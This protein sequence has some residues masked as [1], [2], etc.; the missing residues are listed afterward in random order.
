[1]SYFPAGDVTLT[2]TVNAD[3][4]GLTGRQDDSSPIKLRS[5]H[6]NMDLQY[7]Q[8]AIFSLSLLLLPLNIDNYNGCKW[9]LEAVKFFSQY[10]IYKWSYLC[11]IYDALSEF[12]RPL[13]YVH[14][15]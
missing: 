15:K 6:L 4:M 7:G 9:R 5:Q 13:T 3:V 2:R 12:I 1:M 10:I 11:D 14:L 8:H